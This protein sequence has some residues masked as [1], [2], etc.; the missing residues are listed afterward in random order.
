MPESQREC[1]KICRN[2]MSERMPEDIC[3]KECRNN[4]SINAQ[5]IVRLK[6]HGGDHSKCLI[7][8]YQ[9]STQRYFMEAILVFPTNAKTSK[10]PQNPETTLLQTRSG[11]PRVLEGTKDQD[12]SEGQDQDI[13]KLQLP[14]CPRAPVVPS[15]RRWDWGPWGQKGPVIPNLKRYD[16]LSFRD[17]NL[18]WWFSKWRLR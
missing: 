11:R 15:F 9:E 10:T 14:T 5:K 6:C 3:Q 7:K 18:R 1:Q 13:R 17:D 12:R 8:R 4:V 16:D 2:K